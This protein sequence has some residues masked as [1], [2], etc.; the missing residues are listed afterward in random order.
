MLNWSVG[1]NLDLIFN[2]LFSILGYRQDLN[3]VNMNQVNRMLAEAISGE[4]IRWPR[5]TKQ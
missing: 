1:I 2:I 5:F 3:T 4:T